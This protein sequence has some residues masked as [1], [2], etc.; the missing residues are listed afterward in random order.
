MSKQSLITQLTPAAQKT[1]DPIVK[2]LLEKTCFVEKDYR[3]QV[4]LASYKVN[5]VRDLVNKLSE[6]IVK[7]LMSKTLLELTANHIYE[8]YIGNFMLPENGGYEGK[9]HEN[10]IHINDQVID[11]MVATFVHEA[12]HKAAS[13][14]FHNKSLPY[15]I[16]AEHEF[17]EIERALKIELQLNEELELPI[18]DCTWLQAM[19]KGYKP[20]VI[21]A[22][23]VAW[24]AQYVALNVLQSQLGSI[25]NTSLKFTE[26]MWKYLQNTLIK[27]LDRQAALEKLPESFE[28]TFIPFDIKALEDE[29]IDV[30]FDQG[31]AGQLAF[32]LEDALIQEVLIENLFSDDNDKK[33][34][35]IFLKQHVVNL[36]Q[37]AKISNQELV[38]ENLFKLPTEIL[39]SILNQNITGLVVISDD[40]TKHVITNLCK[41]DKEIILQP[42]LKNYMEVIRNAAESVGLTHLLDDISMQIVPEEVAASEV[43]AMP[44][45]EVYAMP[46]GD[47]LEVHD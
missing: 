5:L 36:L 26:I 39:L 30:W 32:R 23:T 8:I 43:Y 46:A 22:E 2:K 47:V 14:L 11:R 1:L 10:C 45:E 25:K 41:A 29:N 19:V 44:A 40:V 21:P 24:F 27:P 15:K 42:M 16:D 37:N 31:P 18:G 13:R 12:T 34:I 28:P 4:D 35:E 6:L 7:S 3:D 20:D 33:N 9:L 38:V 17:A